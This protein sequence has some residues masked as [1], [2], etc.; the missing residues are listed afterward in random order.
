M[1]H[2]LEF[3][4]EYPHPPD[5]VWEV[6]TDLDALQQVVSGLILFRGLPTGKIAQGQKLTVDVSL[7]GVMPYQPY[8]MQVLALNAKDRSFHSSERGAG[9][10]SWQHH[11]K[12]EETPDGSRLVERIE[13]D[14]GL[15]TPL[16]RAWALLLYKKRHK[17]RL[18]ILQGIAKGRQTRMPPKGA[19]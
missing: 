10:R 9:V 3:I 15:L 1:S 14:A 4:H 7:F 6:A 11:L 19:S 12:V 8:E 2:P 5:R 17:P 13:I 18:A 16:F